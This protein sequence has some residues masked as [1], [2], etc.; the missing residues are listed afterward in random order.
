MFGNLSVKVSPASRL[1]HVQLEEAFNEVMPRKVQL[2][3]A[4]TE[5]VPK[6]EEAA[7]ADDVNSEP[8]TPGSY[9]SLPN[10]IDVCLAAVPV[11]VCP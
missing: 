2:E 6:K 1:F 8:S 3:G 10:M 5:Y 4:P 9:V 7:Q 11:L